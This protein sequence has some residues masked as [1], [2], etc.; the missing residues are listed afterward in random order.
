LQRLTKNTPFSTADT[1]S[2]HPSYRDYIRPDRLSLVK[3][4]LVVFQPVQNNTEMLMLIIVPISLRRDTFSAYHA[5]P[6]AGH[7]GIYKTL[8]R[9]W[10]HSRKAVQIGASNVLTVSLPMVLLLATVSLSSLGPSAALSTSFMSI[11]GNSAKLRIA[12]VKPTS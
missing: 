4:K 3:G 1:N 6:S 5:T 7:M 8:H 11:F 12:V 9:V 2:L 10:P